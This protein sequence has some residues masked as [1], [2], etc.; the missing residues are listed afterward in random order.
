[1][2]LMAHRG[3]SG[4][5]PENTLSAFRLALDYQPQWIE[6][7]VHAT[8][9]GAIVVMH[10]GTVDR[11]TNG[12][13][14]ISD[15][16]LAQL[17]QLDAGSWF[18]S[19]FA[20]EPVPLLAEV[21]ELVAHRTRLD[22]EIKGGPDLEQ[23]AGQVVEILRSG[24]VLGESE[25]SSFDLVA[26]LAVQALTSEPELAL[27]TGNP[28]D[29]ALC[30]EHGFGWLNLYFEGVTAELVAQ[31][32]AA[33]IGIAAW[34]IDDLARWDEFRALGVDIFC[35]DMPHLAPVLGER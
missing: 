19:Q 10:D 1:M 2:E 30:R 24:G 18:G 5:A 12:T 23:T 20:G 35:T 17:R 8:A 7:D 29:L 33:G 25:I 34:T 9:D 32:H 6:L 27:I 21:V 3:A 31:A 4:L 16:T 28:A 15:L 13:G 11:T 22:V 26:I 14:A